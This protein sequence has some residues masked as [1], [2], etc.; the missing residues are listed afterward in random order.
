M[1]MVEE[2]RAV[3]AR[4]DVSRETADR[5][6]RY[7]AL[8]EQWQAKTN[9]VA[10]ATLPHV[11]SRHI[12]DSL[13]FQPLFPEARR[14]VDI[15]SGGGF[16]GLVSAILLAGRDGADVSLIESNA[17]KCAFLRT[18]AR[19]LRLPVTVHMKRIEDCADVMAQAEA[20]S[21]R[22][23]ASLDL[24]CGMVSRRISPQVPCFF[25]KGRNHGE[26]IVDASAHWRFTVT[27]HASQVEDGAA[28]LELRD[29]APR[30]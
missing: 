27:S 21:A 11:W 8:L 29:I 25:A 2:R 6:D 13:Q 4:A 23:L 3:L 9:L 17:K 28:V 26:E 10:E 30:S 20:V 14:W 12:A 1:S 18:V 5:L 15:G 16:P 19:E 7:V 22:A 24:L